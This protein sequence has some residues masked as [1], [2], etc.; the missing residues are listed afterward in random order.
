[1][2]SL[3]V[4]RLLHLADAYWAPIITLVITQSSLGSAL[5]VSGERFAGTVLGAV[6]GAI[7]ASWFAGNVLVFGVS[8][9]ILGL[10]TSA[11]RLNRSAYRF[12]GVTVGIVLLLPREG[13]AW[14]VAFHRFADV[15]IGLGLALM[16][17]VLWPEKE[18]PRSRLE[19][20]AP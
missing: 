16:L 5:V 17:T 9:F 7:V 8:V 1:M 19:S 4:A 20:T 12:A 2:A 11:M 10:L 18:E 6:V 3:I 15:S 13:P 14:R